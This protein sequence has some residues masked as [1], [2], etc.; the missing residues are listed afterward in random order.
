MFYSKLRTSIQ[1]RALGYNNHCEKNRYNHR[2]TCVSK[3][4]G[5]KTEFISSF[6]GNALVWF[7]SQGLSSVLSTYGLETLRRLVF[8]TCVPLLSPQ[9]A[10]GAFLSNHGPS[11]WNYNSRE[12]L[13]LYVPSSFGGS[14][15]TVN[16]RYLCSPGTNSHPSG[17]M[18]VQLWIHDV[19]G[20]SSRSVFRSWRTSF[21]KPGLKSG[22][23]KRLRILKRKLDKPDNS[24]WYQ[25]YTT[26]GEIQLPKEEPP[27]SPRADESLGLTTSLSGSGPAWSQ[28]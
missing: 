19:T 23:L 7:A 9:K 11:L 17:A 1:H 3:L 14:Q 16:L 5:W 2:N 27:H 6:S 18:L 10:F 8:L 21:Q 15:T 28:L 12:I 20:S 25:S 26:P 24:I 13:S 4:S 22:F